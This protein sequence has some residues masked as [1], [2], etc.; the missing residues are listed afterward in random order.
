MAPGA[1]I[2]FY[3]SPS[4]FDDDFLD[5]LANVVDEDRVQLVSNSWGDLEQNESD[6]IPAYENVFLQ[7]ALEGISFMFSSGDNG[8]ELAAL[9]HQADRLPDV[10]PVRRPRSAGP[11]TRSARTTRSSSRPAGARSSTT[12]TRTATSWTL[13]R[14]HLRCRR[15]SVGAVQPARLP[16]RSRPRCLPRRP[17]R[18]S[19]RGPEHRHARRADADLP[20][21]RLLRRVPPRRDEPGLAAVRGHDGARAAERR[22]D[23][24][25]SAEPGDLRQRALRHLHRHQGCPAGT[26]CRPRR[27]SRTASTAVDGIAVL[28]PRCSTR[29]RA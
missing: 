7:G 10:R 8:D 19:G 23:R 14:L 11:R 2:R 12:S 13:A 25:R 24:C 4:C 27:T 26:R 17:G 20:G 15:R 6:T 5:T 16:G 29:T 21:R 1:R 28:G 18:R 3:P 9:R 22:H